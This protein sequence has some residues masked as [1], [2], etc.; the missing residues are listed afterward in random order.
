MYINGI[1]NQII[2]VSRSK[3]YSLFKAYPIRLY[4]YLFAYSAVRSLSN[5]FRS[6][7]FSRVCIK[8]YRFIDST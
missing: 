3:W 5:I 4:I 1:N 8:I 6:K 7:L 2:S